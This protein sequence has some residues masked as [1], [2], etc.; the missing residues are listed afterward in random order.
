VKSTLAEWIERLVQTGDQGTIDDE[1][2]AHN[3]IARTLCV[4]LHNDMA[5]ENAYWR[6]DTEIDIPSAA[7][8]Q[9]LLGGIFRH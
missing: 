3:R 2:Q 5:L 6:R 7:A 8:F 4:G 9:Q 1:I